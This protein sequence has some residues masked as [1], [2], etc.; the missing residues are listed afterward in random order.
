MDK[1]YIDFETKSDLPIDVGVHKYLRTSNSDI[2]CMAYAINDGPVRLWLPGA[3][4]PYPWHDQERKCQVYAHNIQFDWQVNNHLGSKYL[5]PWLPLNRCIDVMAL[6]GRYTYFQGLDRAG[7]V[8]KIKTGKDPKGKR[9]LKKIS[10]P[11]FKYTDEELHALYRYCIQDVQSMRELVHALPA[12][13]LTDEEQQIWEDTVLI[14]MNGLPVDLPLAKRVYGTTQYYMKLQEKKLPAITGGA[15]NTI[16]QIAK[17]VEWVNSK[18]VILRSL[19]KEAVAVKLEEINEAMGIIYNNKS[20]DP[21]CQKMKDVMNLETI[22][23]VWNVLTEV[24]TVLEMRQQLGLSSIAKYKRIINQTY[25]GRVY[26]NLR[27]HAASTGRWGGLGFQIHNLPRASVEDIEATIEAFYSADILREDPMYAAKALIRSIIA[28][29]K[30]SK[31]AVADYVGIENRIIAW[32]AGEH[33]I[34]DDFRKGLDEYVVFA[35]G[36]FNVPLDQVTKD[37]RQFSK[38]C[39]LGAGYGLG[40]KGFMGYAEGYGLSITDQE[41]EHAI[42]TYRKTHPKVVNMWYACK[43]AAVK[44]IQ[45]PKSVFIVNNCEFKMVH[46]RNKRK[47]LVLT[48]PSGRN[49]LYESPEVREDKY[50]LIPTHMGINSYNKQWQ[51]LKLI[52]GRIV[53]NI[54]QAL[55]RDILA[56]GV[57]RLMDSGFAICAHIHDEI[58]IQILDDG[59]AGNKEVLDIILEKMCILP[60]WAEGLPLEAEGEILQRFKKI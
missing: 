59:D 37:Q 3:P 57:R 35:S 48:L 49:L 41:S 56:H 21:R 27:Y 22:Q 42:N 2:I 28:A 14:N 51:R 13:R 23:E 1:V 32:V 24:K 53:E 38:A 58:I 30:G 17:I 29:Q 40:W 26:E 55:A 52:P 46:D 12:D 34:L 11:P 39:I 45:Y 54:V 25:G 47:W 8:L 15:V 10:Q 5:L 6:C 9:L 43:D 60:P 4:A 33:T 20:D 31:L 44:A 36:L 19:D 50:G 18:C 16:N 7:K